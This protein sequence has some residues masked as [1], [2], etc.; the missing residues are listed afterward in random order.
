MACCFRNRQNKEGGDLPLCGLSILENSSPSTAAEAWAHLGGDLPNVRVC[1]VEPRPEM[2]LW[3]H[4]W[5][6]VRLRAWKRPLEGSFR[7]RA[8]SVGTPRGVPPGTRKG[9]TPFSGAGNGRTRSLAQVQRSCTCARSLVLQHTKV[10]GTPTFVC[11]Y[12]HSFTRTTSAAPLHLLCSFTRSPSSLLVGLVRTRSAAEL[13]FLCSLV[14]QHQKGS[15]FLVPRELC[16]A[17]SKG[18]EALSR[19]RPVV[20]PQ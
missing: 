17:S 18:L 6:W 12:G 14:L 20:F 16:S 11:V 8:V 19:Q 10:G 4:F 7:T 9:L 3:A 2:G 13:H 1:S 5:A 15:A